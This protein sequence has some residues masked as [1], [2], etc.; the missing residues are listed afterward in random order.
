MQKEIRRKLGYQSVYQTIDFKP[1]TITRDMEGHYIV[2]KGPIQEE[3]IKIVNMYVPNIG[4]PTYIKQ[5]ITDR[6]G[7]TDS[8]TTILWDFNTSFT[9]TEKIIQTESQ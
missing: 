8:N 3:S 5:I 6:K 9:S 7:E 2:I 4:A 1:K